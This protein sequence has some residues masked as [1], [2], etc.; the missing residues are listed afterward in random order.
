NGLCCSQYG[1]CGSTT[2]YCGN[3]CQSQCKP[4]TTPSKPT[5]TPRG[6]GGIGSL[7]SLSIINQL[8]KHRKDESCP[9]HGFYT[10]N[11]FI[12][13]ARSF[14]HRELKKIQEFKDTQVGVLV[15][16]GNPRKKYNYNYASAGKAIGEDL[17][18]NPDS[19]TTDMVISFQTAIWFWKTPQGNKPSSHNVIIGKWTPSPADRSTGRVP[20]YGVITNIINGGL[21]CGRGHDDRVASWIGF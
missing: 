5:P 10:Y 17:I 14:K 3:G 20:G 6:G 11:A 4:K 8:L 2:E 9:S 13:A 19:V 7:I 21:E 1:W 15:L 16:A 18:N 12:T